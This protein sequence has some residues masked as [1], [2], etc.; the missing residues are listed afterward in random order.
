MILGMNFDTT[1]LVWR[2]EVEST[3][4]LP[5]RELVLVDAQRGY[6]TLHFNQVEVAKYREVYDTACTNS[7][8]GTLVRSEGGGA[9][10]DADQDNAYDFAGDTYDFYWNEHGRDSIDGLGMPIISTVDY[11]PDGGCDYQNAFWSGSLNQM[12]YGTGFASAD[13]VVAHEL[14]HGVT[15]YESNLFYYMQSGAISEALSDIWGEF[16]DLSNGGA[17][18]PGDRWLMGEDLPIGAIRSMSNPTLYGDPDKMTSTYYYCGEADNGGVHINSGVGNKAAY[19]MVDGGSFNGYTVTGM[20]ISKTADLWY[21]VQTNLLTSGSDYADL[22]DCLQQAAINLGYNANDR[23]T[24]KDALD[25]TEMNQQPT[26]CPA[27]EAPVCDAGYPI[28]LWFDD[29]EAGDSNWVDGAYYGSSYWYY[30]HGYATS[31][32]YHLYGQDP[33]GDGS[34][35]GDYYIAM[36]VN[37]ALPAGSTPYLHFRHAYAFDYNETDMYDGGV[38]EYSTNGGATWYDAGSLFTHNGYDG[39]IA[40]GYLNP[41]QGRQAFVGMSNGYISSRLDLSSLAGQNVRFR[42]RI[43]IDYWPDYPYLGWIIDDVRIY[44]CDTTDP[45]TSGHN[46]AKGVT[47]VPIDTNIVVHILDD[48]SGVDESTIVMTVEDTP[49]SPTITGTSADFT[50]TYDPPVDFDFLQ[51]VNVTIDAS[52]FAGNAMPTDSY[53]FTTE[54]GDPPVSDPNGPYA[55]VIDTAVTFN[56]SGS[57]DPDGTI[58]SY[59]WDFGD[60]LTGSGVNPSHTYTD[61]GIYTVNLTVT[62]NAGLTDFATTLATIVEGAEICGATYEANGSI[63]GGVTIA[64]DGSASVVSSNNGTYQIIATTTGNHTVTASKAGFRD[65][66][67]VI[68][69]TDLTIPYTLDFKGNNGLVPNAPTLSYVLACIN[70][71]IAPPGDGTELSISKV[72]AV[73]NAWQ[74]PL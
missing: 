39:P 9:T 65:Q 12:V 34:Y 62:D 68:E 63:L 24:V 67:Q 46:P 15:D 66:S 16:V 2:M 47:D 44:T 43:G 71:W 23:Q 38:V 19:L 72:L 52:D 53:S 45:Y 30:A 40:S 32:T 58:I 42:F 69:I 21:E 56:G 18:P 20:G 35:G 26:S 36:N 5:V 4:L 27:N 25:A 37:V 50:L 10:G 17:D 13:D 7:L 74:F 8:P 28:D 61:P 55:G 1:S 6:I 70:K 49:V 33:P 60:N 22:Y 31:G 51:E 59:D 54:V 73:I 14:T 29:L 11:D 48:N 3:D 64:I 57:Y 41:L